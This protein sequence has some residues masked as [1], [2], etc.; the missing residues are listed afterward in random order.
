MLHTA[1]DAGSFS[2][3]R[4]RYA[5]RRFSGDGASR[6]VVNAR[7]ATAVLEALPLAV[8]MAEPDGRVTYANAAA[9]VLFS[10][11]VETLTPADR[12]RCWATRH[13]DG[14]VMSSDDLPT[15][16][17][18]RGERLRN[19]EYWITHADGTE[20]RVLV[21]SE[22]IQDAT[23]RP[24][25]AAC[26]FEDV[27]DRRRAEQRLADALREQTTS[28]LEKARL[29]EALA[30][31]ADRLRRMTEL[32]RLIS[33]SLDT[34]EVL[35]EIG[36]AAADLARAGVVGFWILDAEHAVLELKGGWG[37]AYLR[38]VP[39]TSLRCD[40]SLVGWVARHR[41]ALNVP[42]VL[43]D[44][45]FAF[46]DWAVRNGLRGFLGI[47]ILLGDA[48]IGVLGMCGAQPFDLEANAELF[49]SFVAQAAVA[50]KN[51]TLYTQAEER[52]RG[53]EA[54]EYRA[55]FIAEA[56]QLLRGSLDYAATAEAL[57]RVV[58]PELADLCVVELV[59][60]PGGTVR[61]TAGRLAGEPDEPAGPGD[62]G[63]HVRDAAIGLP[64]M[65]RDGTARLWREAPA[66]VLAALARD[67]ARLRRLTTAEVKCAMVIPIRD[68]HGVLGAMAMAT[69]GSGRTYDGASLRFAETLADRAGEAL[70]HARLFQESEARRR[71]AERLAEYGRALAE[72]RD[73][74][75]LCRHIVRST[76]ELLGASVALLYRLD[77]AASELTAVA[78]A[79]EITELAA[80]GGGITLPKG[81]GVA[82]AAI[83]TRR[84]IVSANV[85]ED[86]AI[87]CPPALRA[88][89]ERTALRSAV[90]VPLVV[91]GVE[92]VGAVV[93]LD[94]AGRHFD[95][96]AIRT[97]RAFSDQAAL[98]LDNARL[99]RQA[100]QR[101]HEAEQAARAKEEFVAVLSHELRT[102]LGAMLGWVRMLGTRRL[103]ADRAAQGLE[104][105]ER[106]VRLLGRLIEDLLDVSRIVAGKMQ[107]EKRPVDVGP[108]IEA[109]VEKLRPDAEANRVA[110]EI[111]AS[112][113][114]GLVLGDPV[115][116]EQILT[117]LVSNAVKFTPAGGRVS[118]QLGRADNEVKVVV[119]DTGEGIDPEVLPYVFDRF[120]QVDGTRTRRRGGL[121]LGLAIVRSLT[122]LHGGTVAAESAGRD[123]GATFTVALPVLAVRVGEPRPSPEADSAPRRADEPR[124][125]G[126]LRVL[127]VDDHR[128]SREM[129]GTILAEAGAVVQLAG[130]ADEA[131]QRLQQWQADVLISDLGMPGL[132][133]FDLIRAVRAQ[134]D[135]EDP[136]PRL[137][138]MALSA[139][140]S[141]EDR[142]RALAAGFQDYAAKPIDPAD[143]VAVVARRARRRAGDPA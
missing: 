139:Y 81:T 49:E 88:L 143:L 27:T 16:R 123:A 87:V 73:V 6:A 96:D 84:T 112:P 59:D 52:R 24:L 64:A 41:Q 36:R 99:Y 45:R 29:S 33:A 79:G 60:A 51:A 137:V 74:G 1:A 69:A 28:A 118:V 134:E 136:A 67:D 10:H 39:S 55:R 21:S 110:I 44:P 89:L 80:L 57:T 34:G 47:P 7:D 109:A 56:T 111:A 141:D 66:A 131:L 53:A 135:A 15:M 129:I 132:D 102:P 95:G 12:A 17:A 101:Q 40:G 119:R 9:H 72:I 22:P 127:V 130:S 68:R 77:P 38:D 71:E 86:P 122:Q 103:D 30:A 46:R 116:L 11:D 5:D 121:G 90:G 126:G 31:R 133:G 70:E 18:I 13:L 42:D 92:I 125:L 25:G 108:V 26:V 8:L 4:T 65:V 19:L 62:G 75:E 35:R 58:V 91:K 114:G 50:V 32:N 105:L 2:G 23:G 61:W 142:A 37:D 63:E 48:L 43:A 115:R 100:E 85:L 78:H 98:A 117:N 128:D 113:G 124:P 83:A 106:N 94:H 138:A 82:G 97:V 76:R 14:S 3:P 120:R 104:T 20:H 107:L 140:A 54:A 93:V